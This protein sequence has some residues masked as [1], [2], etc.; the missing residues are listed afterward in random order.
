[1]PNKDKK[2]AP[3]PKGKPAPAPKGKDAKKKPKK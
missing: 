2:A 1:M 3:A